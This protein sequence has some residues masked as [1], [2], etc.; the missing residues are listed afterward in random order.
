MHRIIVLAILAGLS[1]L[2]PGLAASLTGKW[3]LVS[4]EGN[5][6]FDASKTELAF[7]AGGRAAMTVGCNRMSATASIG[8][9]AL[10]F[11]PIMATKMMCPPRLMSL[12]AAFQN[13][14][15]RTASFKLDGDKLSLID[16]SNTV[17]AT[18][19]RRN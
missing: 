14:I 2:G 4:L 12:E 6:S 17:M 8:D 16:G 1:L 11:G 13:V 7:Q 9:L 19:T 3:Q 5:P 18:F 10:K 15:G